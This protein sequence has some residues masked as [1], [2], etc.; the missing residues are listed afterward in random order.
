[1]GLLNH[2]MFDDISSQ[3]YGFYIDGQATFNAPVR[4]GETVTVPG[5]NGTLFLDDNTFENI[6]VEYKCFF[7]ADTDSDFQEQLSGFRAAL[8]SKRGYLR[9]TDTYHPEEFRLATYKG[10]LK[11]DPIMYNRAGGF[12]LQFDCMP[13]RFLKSGEEELEEPDGGGLWYVYNPTPYDA[14]PLLKIYGY[15]DLWIKGYKL[16]VIDQRIGMITVVDFERHQ[17]T[18]DQNETYSPLDIYGYYTNDDLYNSGDTAYLQARWWV[19][20]KIDGAK[21]G[22][23]SLSDRTIDDG[24]TTTRSVNSD[25]VITVGVTYNKEFG[26]EDAFSDGVSAVVRV[27]YTNQSNVETYEDVV[28][29]VL[30]T[31][32][33]DYIK[34][35][36]VYLNQNA[37]TPL[38][39]T[40]QFDYVKVNSTVSALGNPMYVDMENGEAYKY[41]DGEKVYV[42]QSVWVGE[43]LP[44]LERGRNLVVPDSETMTVK[45]IPRWWTL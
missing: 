1:M 42:N 18:Y 29:D 21:A 40:R 37:I 43:N 44:V 38:R 11:I 32:T 4:R 16:T 20:F 27:N 19:A 6:T 45:I 36:G 10:G 13:Q 15:G 24:V 8:M 41:Q 22:T 7:A 26:I 3:T 14:K 12:K 39:T 28:V 9:L 2:L 5:R 33:A 23:I 30:A 31:F 34:L 35:S 17:N 25:G